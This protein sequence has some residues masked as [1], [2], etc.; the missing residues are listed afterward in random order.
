M[1]ELLVTRSLDATSLH[2]IGDG[3]T[4]HG[5]AVPYDR[6]Q[7]VTDDGQTYYVERFAPHAFA[8]DSVKGG[9][10]VNLYVGHRGDDG[11]RYLGRCVGMRDAHDGLYIDFR[12]NRAHPQA[13]DAR[14]GELSGWS[15]SAKVWRTR[16][17]HIDGKERR[18]R[19]RAGLNHV[20]ATAVP[21][22]PG[23]GVL[24]ARGARFE[25]NARHRIDA[26]RHDV[27]RTLQDVRR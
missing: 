19:E 1:P 3:W 17:D 5:L 26:L 25:L 16:I 8:R 11:E 21:Q 23:A 13:E 20:A 24:V 22:Y 2:P 4:L 27:A 9:R 15:V 12:I 18:T 14:S 7:L 10:W 6:D